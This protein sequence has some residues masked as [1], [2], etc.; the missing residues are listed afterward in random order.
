MKRFAPVAVVAVVAIVFLAANGYASARTQHEAMAQGG[1]YIGDT[2][3]PHDE[4]VKGNLTVIGGD[5]QVDGE[6]DGDVVDI[7]GTVSQSPGA[8]VRGHVNGVSQDYT[9]P[10]APWLGANRGDIMAQNYKTFLRLAYNI[11]ILLAFLIFPVR[12]RM[13]LDR[14]EKHPGLSATAGVLALIAVFPVALL[15]LISIIGIPLLPLEFLAVVAGV[16]IGQAALGLLV[17][18]R[19]YELIRPQTTPSP[20]AALIIGLVVLTA[21]E[22]VPVL[23]GL[24][25]ALV[26]MIGLGAA[27]LAFFHGGIF[28]S[29]AATTVGVPRQPI[30]GPPMNVA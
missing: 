29:P 30:S 13:A 14:V 16:L 8:I 9:D 1:F 18:R 6:V 28:D 27:I 20:L 17:G 5:L 19:L 11:V 26:W 2:I 10:V 3:V 21:A 7:G 4:V 15:L 12:V 22:L 24:V 25:L 23:G